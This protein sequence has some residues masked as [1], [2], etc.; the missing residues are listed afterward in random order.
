MYGGRAVST[1][2]QTVNDDKQTQAGGVRRIA[3]VDDPVTTET[4]P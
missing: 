3:R 4:Q 2:E 1:A